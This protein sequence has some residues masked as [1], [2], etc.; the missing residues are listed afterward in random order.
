MVGGRVH[1][2]VSEWAGGRAG[3]ACEQACVH[4]PHTSLPAC[5]GAHINVIAHIHVIV[6]LLSSLPYHHHVHEHMSA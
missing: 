2:R 5:T 1:G 3:E 4:S 6:P